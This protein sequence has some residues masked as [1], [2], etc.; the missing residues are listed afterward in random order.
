MAFPANSEG[1]FYRKS[2]IS[3][4]EPTI[5]DFILNDD[6]AVRLGDAVD[7]N[8]G[9]IQVVDAG[10]PVL[11]V[12]EGIVDQNGLAVNHASADID[13][14]LNDD[15][16]YTAAADNETDKKV[17]VQCI[18]SPFAVFYN[19]ADSTLTPAEVGRFFDTTATGDQITGAGGAS[20]QFQLISTDPDGDG[21]ASKGLFKI[22]ESQLFAYA[23]V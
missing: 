13:G 19:D 3:S 22:S 14:T 1:F 6:E 16:S 5:F 9:F 17:R 23:Q 4:D 21:D 10:D 11:G 18:V 15:V 7:L 8:V 2:I 12:V 20:G